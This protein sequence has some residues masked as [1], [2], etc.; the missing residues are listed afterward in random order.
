MASDDHIKVTKHGVK[1]NWIE[2]RLE[3]HSNIFSTIEMHSATQDTR[4]QSVESGLTAVQESIDTFDARLD[5]KLQGQCTNTDPEM[6]A[7]RTD[8]INIRARLIP[9][10]RWDLLWGIDTSIKEALARLPDVQPAT[11]QTDKSTSHPP[12]AAGT[13]VAAAKEVPLDEARY[14]TNHADGHTAKG[15]GDCTTEP[16]VHSPSHGDGG[17]TIPP[18]VA[19]IFGLHIAGLTTSGP[20]LQCPMSPRVV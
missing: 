1:L 8:V 7:L 2:A 6:T 4:V 14:A 19:S 15:N 5:A 16:T 11:V 3:K 13:D 18:P 9:D 20:V 12:P 10:L 17:H